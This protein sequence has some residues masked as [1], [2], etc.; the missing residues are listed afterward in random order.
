MIVSIIS[1]LILTV[2]LIFWGQVL[3]LVSQYLIEE[4]CSFK[5]TIYTY[6]SILITLTFLLPLS[7]YLPSNFIIPYS[8]FISALIIS[9]N[10][11]L[12]HMLISRYVTVFL[13]PI[14][15]ILSYYHLLPISLI[16]SIVGTFSA[17]G[18]LS[19][20]SYIYLKVTGMHGLGLGDI[21]L[22]SFIGAW[23]GIGGWWFSLCSGAFLGS[24][25]GIAV[26]LFFHKPL[27]TTKLPF[28]PFLAFGAIGYTYLQWYVTFLWHT[29]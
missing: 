29:P 27:R 10:T 25:V 15:F 16:E 9:I 3:D 21:E 8:F 13:I 24:C 6:I 19:L 4:Q 18:F 17:Y 14:A 7:F 28:G 22:I 12:K 1:I 20:I 23:L 11:D 26:V 5:H 2:L